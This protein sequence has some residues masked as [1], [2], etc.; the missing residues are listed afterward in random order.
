MCAHLCTRLSIFAH[1]EATGRHWVS[2]SVALHFDFLIF[3]YFGDSVSLNLVFT[4]G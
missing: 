2:S 1:V 3:I 4:L